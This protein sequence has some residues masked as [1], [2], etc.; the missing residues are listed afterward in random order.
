MQRKHLDM[1]V[2]N[3]VS[4]TDSGFEVGHNRVTLIL[5]EGAQESWPLLPKTEVAERILE[6]IAVLW[7]D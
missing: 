2:A 5:P 4:S 7:G 3:D 6:R 1:M